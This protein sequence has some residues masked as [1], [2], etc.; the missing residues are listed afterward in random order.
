VF[1]SHTKLSNP[2]GWD[3]YRHRAEAETPI[4]ELKD[5]FGHDGFAYRSMDTTEMAFRWV[6]VASLYK[7]MVLQ[8]NIT[9]RQS[10]RTVIV[11]RLAATW[12]D[13]EGKPG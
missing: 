10:T 8:N 2:R 1:V 11:L 13:R 5:D 9:P 4:N 12:R 3:I 6:T 7:M